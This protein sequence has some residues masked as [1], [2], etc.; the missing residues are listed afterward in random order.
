M[1][2]WV[3]SSPGSPR[4]CPAPA[5]SGSEPFPATLFRRSSSL[6]SLRRP[7]AAVGYVD[8]TRNW[9][10]RRRFLSPSLN[11]VT[12]GPA[13]AATAPVG[14]SV[15]VCVA[16]NCSSTQTA[17]GDASSGAST[18]G[19]DTSHVAG[20][21]VSKSL[22]AVQVGS[23]I[24]SPAVA[25]TAPIGA[26]VPVCVVGTCSNGQTV[27]Q[28]GSSGASTVVGGRE[29]H[30][31]GNLQPPP[32]HVAVPGAKGTKASD[33]RR[34]G[35][36]GSDHALPAGRSAENGPRRG[37]FVPITRMGN[38]RSARSTAECGKGRRCHAALRPK[39]CGFS[40][41]SAKLRANPTAASLLPSGGLS[42]LL[43]LAIGGGLTALTS[44]GQWVRSLVRTRAH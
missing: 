21:S 33:H 43:L 11:S 14:A 32:I 10:G 34:S 35:K 13:V 38:G 26:A 6:L 30:A 5:E 7:R 28:A 16:S 24:V 1:L 42:L 44:L 8:R 23:A 25:V 18:A 19:G 9:L 36:V 2:W 37:V 27:G 15:P 40:G 3:R 41:T 17:G 4:V 20:Q 39:A 22:G 29:S 12:V 31:I